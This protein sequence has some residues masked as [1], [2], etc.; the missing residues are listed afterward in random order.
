MFHSL[1]P[2][3]LKDPGGL[4]VLLVED[5]QDCVATVKA[6]LKRAP[7]YA[8]KVADTLQTAL[9]CLQTEEV[10]VVLLDLTLPD[11]VGLETF[12]RIQSVAPRTP[13]IVLS[14]TDDESL[15]TKTV[16]EGAQ[17]YLVKGDFTPAILI[18]TIRY[19]VERARILRALGE[20]REF[21]RTL[22][23]AI[24]DRMYVKDRES[25]FVQINRHLTEVLHLHDP[26]EAL[27]KTDF[28]FFRR[29]HAQEAFDEEEKI[30]R[31][32]QPLVGK[33]EQEVTM[34][35]L[36][37]WLITTKMPVRDATGK[38]VGTFGLSKD[39]SEIKRGEEALRHS[40]ERFRGLLESVMDY[41]YTV[42]LND[43][44]LMATLHDDGCLAVTGY[45]RE[46]YEADAGLWARMI[47]PQDVSMVVGKFERLLAGGTAE[48]V[49]HRI[50]HK[51]G[52]VRWIRNTPTPHFDAA[53]RL[54]SYDGVV[55]DITERKE[56]ELQLKSANARLRELVAQLTESH[57]A[58]QDAQLDL[59][60][61]AKMRSL[62]QLAAGIAHEVKNP[63]AILL[64][65][66]NCLAEPCR[67][68]PATKDILLEMEAAIDRANTIITELLDFSSSKKLELT[69]CDLNAIVLRSL[70]YVR[71]IV[72]QGKVT[73]VRNL[74]VDLP[75]VLADA[76]KME[77][78][79][80]NLFTNACHAMPQGGT[81]TVNTALRTL[82]PQEVGRESSDRSGLRLDAGEEV[83]SIEVLDTGTG[84]PEDKL[85]RIFDPFFSTKPVGKGTG[86][87]LAVTRNIIELHGGRIEIRNRPEG[88]AAVALTLRRG[89]VHHDPSTPPAELSASRR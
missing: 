76:A 4:Q 9:R 27:G 32:G 49:E 28:D 14:G 59:I 6:V 30:M 78:V 47:H 13:I 25:R 71:H 7:Q 50:L 58:L 22:L 38:I 62:G 67:N 65:G 66:V 41:H 39:I 31:T 53:G 51:D 23:D 77:Q 79:L 24:P 19:A 5:N 89:A 11:S 12:H 10:D 63:L 42:T 44:P 60:D 72:I 33:L 52:S 2:A 88:G 80:I 35:G 57:R 17:D 75:S 74:P 15:A 40:E 82:H 56:A 85:S 46:E 54:I 26:A 55:A 34:D 69:E 37:T 84:I 45:R 64:I 73:V 48:A 83:L 20:E 81:L 68:I 61:A 70:D 36:S 87:G 43:G 21:A 1:P 8:I 16:Q 3:H 86:L 18:R 29:D